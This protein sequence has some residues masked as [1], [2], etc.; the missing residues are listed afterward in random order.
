MATIRQIR[1]RIRSVTSTAKIT[2]AM[3]LVAASKMRRAQQRAL[4]TR[5]YAD[6]MRRVLAGLAVRR[7]Q[8]EVLHPFLEDRPLT[9]ALVV[10]IT[11]DRGL[12]GGLVA[13]ANRRTA[14][15]AIDLNVPVRFVTVG[16][17][18]RDFLVRS[19]QQV[20]AEFSKL[21][22]YP[23]VLD[24]Q[25]IARVVM[26]EYLAGRADRVFLSFP[27]FVNTVTQR[28]EVRRLL[29]VE[30]PPDAAGQR[31]IDYIYEPG[32]A[33]VLAALLPRYVEMQVYHAVLETAASEQSAR[34]VAMRNATDA[35][36]DMIESLTLTY[37]KARQEQITKEL[38]D[39][40]GGVAGLEKA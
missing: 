24:T 1:R 14:A 22:D 7:E 39:I 10:H 31:E 11:P 33:E 15:F 2:K 32:P 25:P 30:P 5:P 13:N 21:G 35:A 40:V 36:N 4:A 23:G 20:I 27:L 18:G 6:T 38:L 34:M 12:C 28:P 26:D 19:G 37:N 29:P 17:K 16:A 9:S 8:H 3:E